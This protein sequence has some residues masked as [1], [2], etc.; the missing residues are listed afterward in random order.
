MKRMMPRACIVKSLRAWFVLLDT[1][2][3][4]WIFVELDAKWREP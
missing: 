2:L 4:L 3:K 1:Y